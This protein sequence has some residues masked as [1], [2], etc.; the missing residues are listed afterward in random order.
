M[1]IIKTSSLDKETILEIYKSK[2]V[3]GVINT[4]HDADVL[5]ILDDFADEVDTIIENE[6]DFMLHMISDKIKKE[7]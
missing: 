4:Y 3:I 2:G 6:D 7:I 5:I 1:S